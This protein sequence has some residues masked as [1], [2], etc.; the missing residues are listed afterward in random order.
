MPGPYFAEIDVPPT[1]TLDGNLL[2]SMVYKDDSLQSLI[3]KRLS[4]RILSG[5]GLRAFSGLSIRAGFSLFEF[6]DSGL[7]GNDLQ[8][9]RPDK[10]Q[11]EKEMRA[12][13]EGGWLTRHCVL[14]D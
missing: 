10:C 6:K 1:H 2:L 12:E 7:A 9:L 8:R 4:R 11:M 14:S 13:V 3:G 5:K